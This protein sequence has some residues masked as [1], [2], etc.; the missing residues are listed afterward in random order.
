MSAISTRTHGA[1][2]YGVAT[3][4]GGLAASR[5]LPPAVRGVL[6]AA[7]FCRVMATPAAH[8]ATPPSASSHRCC[9]MLK[10]GRTPAS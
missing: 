7:G 9:R 1:I 3:L 10:R 6:G 4:F 5:S 2:D 8:S